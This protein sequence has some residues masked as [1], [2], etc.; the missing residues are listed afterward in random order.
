MPDEHT[1][2]L[3]ETS[4]NIPPPDMP[5]P[6]MPPPDMPPPD[7]GVPEA[8]VPGKAAL[9]KEVLDRLDDAG[10]LMAVIS[11]FDPV[12]KETR[13]ID[14]GRLA[15]EDPVDFIRK[16]AAVNQRLDALDRLKSLR[17]EAGVAQ[18][19]RVREREMAALLQKLPDWNDQAKRKADG[20][21]L[22]QFLAKNG[23]TEAEIAGAVDHRA[24]LLAL[25]AMRWQEAGAER[26]AAEAKRMPLTPRSVGAPPGELSGDTRRM[27]QLKAR[28]LKTGRTDDQVAAVLAAL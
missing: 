1:P 13:G 23:F 9:G 27:E 21:K 22:A 11:E 6:D 25:D 4:Q 7:N 5:P 15:Q 28:A 8:A 19:A 17:H 3:G 18:Q 20:Q 24:I 12:L 26:A 2:P 16:R 10:L 14:W